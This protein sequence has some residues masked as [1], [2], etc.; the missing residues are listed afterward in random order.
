MNSIDR[1]KKNINNE[2]IKWVSEFSSFQIVLCSSIYTDWSICDFLKLYLLLT[3]YR[4]E[5]AVG[6]NEPLFPA[7]KL[8]FQRVTS[9]GFFSCTFSFIIYSFSPLFLHI[10]FIHSCPNIA[11]W[12]NYQL[13]I[14]HHN[15]KG[16][17]KQKHVLSKEKP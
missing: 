1:N 16:M 10:S 5:P 12:I 8:P 13:T 4:T 11:C 14:H 2:I 3:P 7:T 17:H 9:F 6:F 15:D